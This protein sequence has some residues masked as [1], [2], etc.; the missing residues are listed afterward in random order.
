[1]KDGGGG[2]RLP[3]FAANK[4]GNPEKG[5][6]VLCVRFFSGVALEEERSKLMNA[7]ADPREQR[8]L[9]DKL[10]DLVVDRLREEYERAGQDP[11][12]LRRKRNATKPRLLANAV[13]DHRKKIAKLL[14]EPPI[15]PDTLTAWRVRRDEAE[16]EAERERLAKRARVVSAEASTTWVQLSFFGMNKRG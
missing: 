6:A 11:P 4:G 12:S 16:R 7:Q 15:D 8:I 3:A 13:E 9:V 5:R 2:G 14:R 1:M 10:H